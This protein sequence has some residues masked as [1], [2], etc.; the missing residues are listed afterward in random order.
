M[1]EKIRYNLDEKLHRS[2]RN[3]RSIKADNNDL[4]NYDVNS[5][6]SIIRKNY[7][8]NMDFDSVMESKDKIKIKYIKK[9][10]NKNE[11][12]GKNNNKLFSVYSRRRIAFKEKE[13]ENK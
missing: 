6:E 7:K 8:Q 5:K 13:K 4:N 9:E 12:K 10:K 1:Q 3:I 11:E 2:I